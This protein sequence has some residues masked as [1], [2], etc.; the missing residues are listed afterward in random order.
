MT[1]QLGGALIIAA[2]NL[3]LG[4]FVYRLNKALDARE[5]RI[6]AIDGRVQAIELSIAGDL[7]G[8]EDKNEL[9]ARLDNLAST[10][11]RVK[12]MVTRLD[13]REKVRHERD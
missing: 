9:V 7:L 4:F 13:E 6:T 3:V 5:A 10:L 2:I 12:D 1:P 8:K 11:D